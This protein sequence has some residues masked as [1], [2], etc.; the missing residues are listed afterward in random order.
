MKLK[1]CLKL[2]KECGL[3]TLGECLSNIGLHSSQM[4]IY[5]KMGEE[6]AELYEEASV[7][8][9]SDSIDNILVQLK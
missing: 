3:S 1:N 7:F 5:T 4:F 9:T 2:G 8:N 6:L